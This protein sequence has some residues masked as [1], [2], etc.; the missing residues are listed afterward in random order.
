MFNKYY[1]DELSYLREMGREFSQAHPDAAPYLSEAGADPD[2]ERLLEGFA[3]L[4]GRIRQRLD[5]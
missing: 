2:V 1:Q 5:D 3:F 4:S